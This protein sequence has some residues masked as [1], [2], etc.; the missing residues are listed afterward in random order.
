MKKLILILVLG[1]ASC[2]PARP[3]FVIYSAHKLSDGMYVYTVWARGWNDMEFSSSEQYKVG[4]T[5]Y[6]TTNKY[7]K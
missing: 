5:L 6:F 1:L 3:P 4:D 7:C 2:D